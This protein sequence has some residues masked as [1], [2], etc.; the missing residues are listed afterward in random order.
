MLVPAKANVVALQT[1]RRLS[2]AG[3]KKSLSR[4]FA[5]VS[6]FGDLAALASSDEYVEALRAMTQADRRATFE[7]FGRVWQRCEAK[8]A[9]LAQ[10]P[11]LPKPVA[12]GAKR[13]NWRDPAIVERFRAAVLS[14]GSTE[15]AGRMCGISPSGAKRQWMRMTAAQATQQPMALAA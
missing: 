11:A 12:P 9:K 15:A 14:T 1:P 2:S 4:R 13:T 3:H 8:A 5:K 7:M 6:N 10:L